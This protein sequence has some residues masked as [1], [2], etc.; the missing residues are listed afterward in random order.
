ML[1]PMMKLYYSPG[2][3]S[4]SIHISL[5]EA[6]LEFALDRVHLG[7][8]KTQDGLDFK[9]INPKGYVP[10]LEIQPGLVLTEGPAILR[11]LADQRPEAKLWPEGPALETYRHLEWLAFISSELHKQFSPLFD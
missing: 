10:T 9:A 2:A 3:C 7:S 4:L 1:A 11:Y 6:G 5:R 8:K